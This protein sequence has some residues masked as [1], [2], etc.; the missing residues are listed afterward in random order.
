MDSLGK[1]HQRLGYQKNSNK[2]KIYIY[3]NQA[4]YHNPRYIVLSKSVYQID[5]YVKVVIPVTLLSGC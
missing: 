5:G 4:N 2:P 3:I 1:S